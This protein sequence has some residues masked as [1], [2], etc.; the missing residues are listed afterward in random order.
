MYITL[1]LLECCADMYSKSIAVLYLLLLVVISKELREDQLWNNGH[2]FHH[3]NF[4]DRNR[5]VFSDQITFLSSLSHLLPSIPRSSP[6]Q[7]F[8]SPHSLD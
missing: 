3:I 2:C 5:V 1:T 8:C 4:L 7:P 6:L